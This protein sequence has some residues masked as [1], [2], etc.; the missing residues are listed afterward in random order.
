MSESKMAENTKMDVDGD[1]G[2]ATL[3]EEL[4]S[5]DEESEA[6]EEEAGDK[7]E[8]V[9]PRIQQLELQVRSQTCQNK[10]ADILPGCE[11]WRILL[12]DEDL[13]LLSQHVQRPVY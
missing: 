12:G 10:T 2:K 13:R 7:E 8:T 5:S 1:D 11:S 4:E 3:E 9:D 6:E